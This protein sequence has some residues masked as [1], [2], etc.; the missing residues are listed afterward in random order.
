MI[1]LE[2]VYPYSPFEFVA[3][4]AIHSLNV[5]VSTSSKQSTET[6]IGGFCCSHACFIA[7]YRFKDASWRKTSIGQP[8]REFRGGITLKHIILSL[9]SQVG[10]GKKH[11]GSL[12]F[13][14]IYTGCFIGIPIM[15]YCNP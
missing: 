9:L 7:T 6:P 5:K 3:I 14:F 2:N 15:V 12:T 11:T 8:R 10:Q 13:H 4:F 1:I